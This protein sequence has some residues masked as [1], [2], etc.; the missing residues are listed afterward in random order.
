MDIGRTA[1]DLH[2]VGQNAEQAPDA[3]Y[4]SSGMTSA[5]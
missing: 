1:V 3:R 5:Q 4:Q 2:W